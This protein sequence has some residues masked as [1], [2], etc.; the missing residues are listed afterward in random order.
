MSSLS[1][2]NEKN[3]SSKFPRSVPLTTEVLQ[4]FEK[5]EENKSTADRQKEFDEKVVKQLRER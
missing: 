5:D 3:D 4:Q 1:N 2:A